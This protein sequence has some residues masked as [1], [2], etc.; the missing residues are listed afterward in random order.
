MSNE[1]KK[2]LISRIA[3]FRGTKKVNDSIVYKL[4]SFVDEKSEGPNLKLIDIDA[5]GDKDL[6]SV[7]DV[8]HGL[9]ENRPSWFKTGKP[10]PLHIYKNDGNGNFT[11]DS[12][13]LDNGQ[14]IF[15]DGILQINTVD[16]FGNSDGKYE[17][18]TKSYADYSNETSKI[19]KFIIEQVLA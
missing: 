17:F 1:E 10:R 15:L 19:N 14:M 6:I 3:F 4:D 8:W 18:L 7:S 16:K 9:N 13:T 12:I 11:Q 5:D 2:K